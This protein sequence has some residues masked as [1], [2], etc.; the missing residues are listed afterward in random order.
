LSRAGPLAPHPLRAGCR[1]PAPARS[2]PRASPWPA[3]Q[4]RGSPPACTASRQ[5][6]SLGARR[7]RRGT[8]HSPAVT[9]SSEKSLA[10][11][12]AR[13]ETRRGEAQAGKRDLVLLESN[14]DARETHGVKVA[15][16]IQIEVAAA[17]QSR[18]EAASGTVARVQ[19]RSAV[20]DE[21]MSPRPGRPACACR[22]PAHCAPQ[23]ERQHDDK[24]AR[25]RHRSSA[26]RP[27]CSLRA[28]RARLWGPAH[29][30]F[31]GEQRQAGRESETGCMKA[32]ALRLLVMLLGARRRVCASRMCAGRLRARA[33]TSLELR[34]AGG[35]RP[36][37]GQ[38]GTET[39]HTQY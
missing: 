11:I 23:Q 27:P 16:F 37:A 34:C 14:A 31:V 1:P 24:A 4:P 5:A 10:R 36:R 20:R 39:Q 8:A 22:M 26:C 32:L 29:I 25:D 9:G 33:P 19:R 12:R 21:R 17:P 13:E 18:H 6:R 3:T 28:S 15:L 35:A 38:R 2:A 30:G 7:R